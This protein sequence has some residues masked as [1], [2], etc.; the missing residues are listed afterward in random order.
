[1]DIKPTQDYLIVESGKFDEAKAQGCAEISPDVYG[2]SRLGA[3]WGSEGLYDRRLVENRLGSEHEKN[4]EDQISVS[5]WIGRR[6][7]ETVG[8]GSWQRWQKTK[9]QER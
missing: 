6:K 1:V 5:V 4:P 2:I 8:G 3:I 7:E 9:E